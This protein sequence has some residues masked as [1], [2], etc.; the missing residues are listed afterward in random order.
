MILLSRGTRQDEAMR[1][2]IDPIVQRAVACWNWKCALLSATARSLVY[3]VAMIR[4]RTH[5]HASIV[6]V[7]IAYVTLTAGIWAGLQQ[8]ALALRSRMLGNLCIA[9]AVPALAQTLD[10]LAHH[11]AGAPV[12]G[13][14][15]ISVCIFTGISALFHLHAMRRGAFI[16]GSSG[17]ALAHDFRAIPGLIAGFVLFPVSL[18]AKSTGRLPRAA[19]SEAV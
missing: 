5:G 9:L 2:T 13:R 17:R 7:E 15:T 3:L 8:R 18:F 10:W 4:T 14:A 12:S 16:T 11:V 6:L 1:Q 19:Q